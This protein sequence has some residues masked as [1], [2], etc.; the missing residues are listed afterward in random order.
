MNV[1]PESDMDFHFLEGIFTISGELS[2]FSIL[3]GTSSVL[4]IFLGGTSEKIH[5]VVFNVKLAAH[6]DQ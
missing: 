2:N 3:G 6:L 5:P 4:R 1:W